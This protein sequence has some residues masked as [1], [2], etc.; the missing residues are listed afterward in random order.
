[1][2]I[3]K[4]RT[5]ENQEY[6]D[7][8][9]YKGPRGNRGRQGNPGKTPVKGID[10]WTDEDKQKII[11]RAFYY[12]TVELDY[13]YGTGTQYIKTN[14]IPKKGD[15]VELKAIQI[16]SFSQQ[17]TQYLF[18]SMWY[19]LDENGKSKY[20]YGYMSFGNWNYDYNPGASGITLESITIPY[21]GNGLYRLNTLIGHYNDNQK[22]PFYIFAY[23]S[24]SNG[25][26]SKS[27][28]STKCGIQSIKIWRDDV[29]I[30]DFRACL[31]KEGIPC[32]WEDV[33]REY[34]YSEAD[35]FL[36]GPQKED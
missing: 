25:T 35:D 15:R 29:M 18:G 22:I 9:T 3:V 10:Y 32:M 13:I 8:P 19:G 24:L 36:A 17:D 27:A 23:N 30:C 12:P 31:D 4:I 1:M 2:S 16:T 26:S 34:Y 7:I 33:T 14:F 21:K 11:D 20:I 6:I 28:N 5:E